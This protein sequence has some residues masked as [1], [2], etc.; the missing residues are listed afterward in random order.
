VLITPRESIAQDV[1][2]V[3]RQGALRRL[4]EKRIAMIVHAEPRIGERFEDG[5]LE[6]VNVYT[7][8]VGTIEDVAFF[9]WSTPR[10]PQNA[11]AAPLREACIEVHLAGDCISARGVMAATAEGHRAGNRI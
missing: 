1:P 5:V 3:T 9:A 7:G 6:Y 2:L 11:L 4:H 10:E 8:D